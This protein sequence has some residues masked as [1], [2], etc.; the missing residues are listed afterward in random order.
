MSNACLLSCVVGCWYV[1]WKKEENDV[2]AGVGRDRYKREG[3]Y[4]ECRAITLKSWL[5]WLVELKHKSLFTPR[6]LSCD[7]RSNSLKLST[8][9][10]KRKYNRNC[11][12]TKHWRQIYKKLQFCF[13]FN[14]SCCFVGLDF[15][16]NSDSDHISFDPMLFA[17]HEV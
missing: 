7:T 2:H 16:V 6:Q 12:K 3:T 5:I 17:E 10:G 14:L 1:V 4:W 13:S 8:L 9:I 15:I 11:W